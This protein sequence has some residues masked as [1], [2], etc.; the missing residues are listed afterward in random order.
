MW[1]SLSHLDNAKSAVQAEF[2]RI[3]FNPSEFYQ[4]L[5]IKMERG[6]YQKWED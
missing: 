6:L 5:G 1:E 2:K 4:R 3:N